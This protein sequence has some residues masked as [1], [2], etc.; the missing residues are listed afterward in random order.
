MKLF[1]LPL[2]FAAALP[3]AAIAGEKVSPSSAPDAV[4]LWDGGIGLPGP[5]G[6]PGKKVL[7]E[8]TE[9]GPDGQERKVKVVEKTGP[10]ARPQLTDEALLAL[11]RRHDPAL[12]GKL[13]AAGNMAVAREA[14]LSMRA[15][16]DETAEK[17]AL[18]VA[19]LEISLRELQA[20]YDKAPAAGKPALR[21]KMKPALAEL[22][23]I[24]AAEQAARL[25][26]MEAALVRLKAAHEKRAAGKDAVVEERLNALAPLPPAPPAAPAPEAK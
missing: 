3:A 16:G 8:K 26:S 11:A 5:A 4:E 17:T 13:S 12:A 23:E 6:K 18:R 1:I 14:L 15:Q 7:W 25:K 20:E 9:K 19:A 22:F 24:R 21:E 10:G 2:L